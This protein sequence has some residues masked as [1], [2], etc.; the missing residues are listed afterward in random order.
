MS[1][2]VHVSF[3]NAPSRQQYVTESQL[4]TVV[5]LAHTAPEQLGNAHE[6][7]AMP[8]MV[9]TA[10]SA[11]DTGADTWSR[12]TDRHGVGGSRTTHQMRTVRPRTTTVVGGA[13]MRGTPTSGH[14]G[15]G[16]NV[17][18]VKWVDSRAWRLVTT[19]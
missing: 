17:M 9:T 10:T 4:S 13:S 5:A 1:P 3:L 7:T 18:L 19:A 12:H 14:E 16:S 8:A 6:L 15:E 11:A 2:G